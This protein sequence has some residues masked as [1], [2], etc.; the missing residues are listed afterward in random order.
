MAT[1]GGGLVG[2]PS[3]DWRRAE[4][5]LTLLGLLGFVTAS[6]PN[7]DGLRRTSRPTH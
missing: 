1:Q 6:D 7:H 3:V 4:F 2:R 5:V